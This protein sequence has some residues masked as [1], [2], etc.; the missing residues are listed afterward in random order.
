[1]NRTG[2]DTSPDHAKELV[3]GAEQAMPSSEGDARTLASYREK[4]FLEAD[5]IG[6]IPA[7]GTLKG[8]AKTGLQKLM[9]NQPEV[10]LDKLAG[11]L[12]FERTGTRLYDALLGKCAVRR[13]EAESLPMDQLRTFR[14]EEAAHFALVWEAIRQLGADPTAQTP[15]ADVNG[16]AS[17]GLMQVIADP[18]TTIAQS[19]HAIHIAELTDRDGW[20]LLIKLVRDMGQTDMASQFEQALTEETRHL[21]TIRQLM[22]DIVMAEASR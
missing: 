18:R 16:V 13:D 19:L 6:T 9:G 7:P 1:M 3:E 10:L 17:M 5:P 2:L 11:R 20:E 8:V 4:D 12:A 22:Q 14:D 21:E 15:E